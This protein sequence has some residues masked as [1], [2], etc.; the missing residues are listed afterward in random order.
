MKVCVFGSASKKT[1]KE[2][3]DVGYELGLRLAENGHHLVFGGGNDG[4]MGAVASGVHDNNGEITAIAPTWIDE[5]D[6][7]F[8]Y[9]QESI[10]TDTMHE[11]KELFLEKSDAFIVC[12][13]GIG[14]MDELFDFLTLKD[15]GRHDKK[16]ILF[17]INHFYEM[18][19]SMLQK[20]HYEG[21]IGDK[22]GSLVEVAVT[23]D[24]LLELL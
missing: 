1:P 22:T 7:E 23:L 21:F 18:L 24:E 20:M 14:T 2:Y 17:S 16:I 4:M 8:E 15:L 9:A 12:P 11:R 6:D 10:Q 5:F 19:F 13:G 3:T